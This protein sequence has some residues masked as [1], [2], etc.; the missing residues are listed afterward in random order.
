MKN[1]VQEGCKG[2]EMTAPVGGVVSGLPYKIGALILVAAV[3]KAAGEKFAGSREGV[4][5]F[6][7]ASGLVLAEGDEVKWDAATG[8]IVATADVAGD[9]VLGYVTEAAPNGQSYA[10][11][12][13]KAV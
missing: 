12:V 8:N 7:K 6:S 4:F 10:H 1:Y 13:L 3:T 11:V 2:L 9:Y 5:K